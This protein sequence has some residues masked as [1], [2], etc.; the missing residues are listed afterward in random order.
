MHSHIRSQQPGGLTDLQLSEDAQQSLRS[1]LSYCNSPQMNAIEAYIQFKPGM[2][3][4]DGD[5]TVE[6]TEEFLRNYITEFGEFIR[7]V[8][9][10]IHSD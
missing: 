6:K 9:V 10:A 1:I 7:R 5:V 4:E 8:C 3:T 2:I